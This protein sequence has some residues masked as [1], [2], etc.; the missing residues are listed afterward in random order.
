MKQSEHDSSEART[1]RVYRIAVACALLLAASVTAAESRFGGWAYEPPPGWTEARRSGD[2]LV[3]TLEAEGLSAGA[4]LTMVAGA[5]MAGTLATA[6]DTQWAKLTQGKTVLRT[7]PAE[8]MEWSETVVGERR[9]GYVASAGG[10]TFLA[11]DGYQSNGRAFF[12]LAEGRD[13]IA[14]EFIGGALFSVGFS[15]SFESQAVAEG[16][17]PPRATATLPAPA[18]PADERLV[19]QMNE[20]APSNRLITSQDFD[21]LE[22]PEALNQF[23]NTNRALVASS[24]RRPVTVTEALRKAETLTATLVSAA[25]IQALNAHPP[26]ASQTALV[27]DA[28]VLL[29]QGAIGETLARLI[30]AEARGAN[31]PTVRFNLA[32]VMTSLGMPNEALALLDDL[33]SA[34]R[35]PLDAYG[36]APES[37]V[38]YGRG[39][40][41]LAVGAIDEARLVLSTVAQR[42]K[43]FAE[44]ALA[45]AL[46]Q[47]ASNQNPRASYVAGYFRRPA[48]AA[49]EAPG[50]TESAS[51]APTAP[52]STQ[53]DEGSSGE[54][55]VQLNG[56]YFVDVAKG[57]P[58]VIPAIMQPTVIEQQIAW[59]KKMVGEMPALDAQALSLTRTR[60]A[61]DKAWQK[62]DLPPELRDRYIAVSRMLSEA[63]APIPEIQGLRKMRNS[64]VKAQ[65]DIQDVIFKF[66]ETGFLDIQKRHKAQFP[67]MCP[68]LRALVDEASARLRIDVQY[69]DTRER[70]LHRAWHQ[71]A[72]ALGS[73]VADPAF[74]AYLNAEIR[75]A[76]HIWY[77]GL[78][79]NITDSTQYAELAADCPM[80][81]PVEINLAANTEGSQIA[82][83]DD[84]AAQSGLSGGSGPVSVN[85]SCDGIQIVLNADLGPLELT[86]EVNVDDTGKI[87]SATT[88]A[89][90]DTGVVKV[91]GSTTVDG[92]GKVTQ[93]TTG[94]GVDVGAVAVS[95]EVQSDGAGDVTKGSVGA[96]AGV[97]PV[98]VQGKGSAKANGDVT[99]YAGSK[100]G[101]KGS[102][103]GATVA[104]EVSGGVSITGNVNSGDINNVTFI[105]T[106]NTSV[107]AGGHTVGGQ[108][109]STF[110]IV[111]GPATAR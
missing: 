39:Q 11:I 65:T 97:G 37:F 21:E 50:S 111:T 33:S 76:N 13:E 51:Q 53:P 47:D 87:T 55:I 38:E 62:K 23:L 109:S 106:A 34:R 104:A 60:D 98:K 107:S 44:A 91:S 88:G 42:E 43:S 6:L 81:P 67:K 32:S 7:L 74:R 4:T 64:A 101:D 5:P 61:L 79:G 18:P 8:P 83:C 1:P 99:I 25:H 100:L 36:I 15:A 85:I 3:Y 31:D 41:L 24:S 103:A 105:S 96:S 94:G 82:K 92:E 19:E 75:L 52:T 89:E 68:E 17:S 108:T 16:E 80:D 29:T 9:S 90:V 84:R 30:L 26:Y 70:R 102:G 28:A 35:A 58:G 10:E 12:L 59:R 78:V 57:T 45:L 71:Y 56:V 20:A 95:G 86:A 69:V 49:I 27:N 2:R 110:V 48:H 73:L 46:A 66:V 77:M 22:F 54:D 93:R 40:A 72:T 63:N 14:V